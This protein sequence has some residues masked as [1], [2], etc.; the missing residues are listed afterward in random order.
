M[1]LKSGKKT[2]TVKENIKELMDKGYDQNQAIAIAKDQASKGY[3][4]GGISKLNKLKSKFKKRPDPNP[5]QVSEMAR[6]E[7]LKKLKDNK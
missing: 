3:E 7:A 1:P 2:K 4:N 6:K 5:R